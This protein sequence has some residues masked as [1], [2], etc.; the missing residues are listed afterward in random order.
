MIRLDE[1]LASI[2]GDPAGPLAS[3]SV[4]AMRAGRVVYTQQFGRRFISPDG[5]QGDRAARADTLYRIASISKLVTTLGVL[6]LVEDG[7]MG[8][9]ADASELLGWTLRNP[10]FPGVRVTPRMMMS[11]TSSIRDEGGYNWPA[12]VKLRD[13]LEHNEAMW[14]REGAPGAYFSYANLPWGLLGTMVERAAGERFD[15]FMA[16]HILAPLGVD[17]TYNATDLGVRAADRIATLYRKRTGDEGHEVWHPEGPW[18]AQVDDYSKGPPVSR[19]GD[20]YEIGTNATVQ[21]PQGGL[22]ASATHLGRV[23][24]LLLGRGEIEGRRILARATVEEM[25]RPQWSFD[26]RN[27]NADYAV[28][29]RRFNEWGLGNQHFLDVSGPGEGDRL[30]EG[31]GFRAIGHLGD[32]YGLTSCMAL[33]PASGDGMVFLS[34]GSAFDPYAQ[35]G[36][37]S[38]LSRYEE[39][40]L[41]A[42]HRRAIRGIDP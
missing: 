26:G 41:T 35:R 25:L 28:T 42:L 27:G 14:G 23:M 31:G 18:I 39:R 24:Q 6:K 10:H 19:V 40:I 16:K 4:L 21:G 38:A 13:V 20:D 9:D 37:W 36:T 7:K 2:A 34:G 33:D 15:R 1:E 11:H 8:L 22:R 17:A 32:A 29:R 5:P 12:N 30:V 3:L